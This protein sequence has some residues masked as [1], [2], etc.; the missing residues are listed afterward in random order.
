MKVAIESNPGYAIEARRGYYAPTGIEDAAATAKREIEDAIYSRSETSDL[1][2]TM[3]TQFS[4]GAGDVATVPY[5]STWTW[6]MTVP[7]GGWR[8]SGPHYAGLGAV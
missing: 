6:R 2:V 3:D 7:Q 5:W 1:P 8:Q 4:K